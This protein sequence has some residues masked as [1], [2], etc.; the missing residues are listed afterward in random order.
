[1]SDAPDS[2]RVPQVGHM[3][4]TLFAFPLCLQCV[5]VCVSGGSEE[6]SCRA[7]CWFQCLDDLLTTGE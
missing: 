6:S 3:W 1:M 4:F 2:S 7:G 5:C